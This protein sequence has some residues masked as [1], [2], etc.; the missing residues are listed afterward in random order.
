MPTDPISS[1]WRLDRTIPISLVV[2]VL[3]Q[4]AAGVWLFVDVKKDV[5]IL[6]VAVA[7]QTA[8][9]ARQDARTASADAEARETLVRIDAK[10]DRIILRS[11]PGK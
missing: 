4:C 11:W 2:L 7:N 6:K 1:T 9:D 5:E 3:S 8:I 10:L